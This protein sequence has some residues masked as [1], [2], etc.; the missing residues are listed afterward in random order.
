MGKRSGLFVIQWGR[1]PLWCEN[2]LEG[3]ALFWRLLRSGMCWPLAQDWRVFWQPKSDVLHVFLGNLFTVPKMAESHS[4]QEASG[5]AGRRKERHGLNRL[6][7]AP[8]LV[9]VSFPA[10]PLWFL[11]KWRP[12][13][14][15]KRREE[16]KCLCCEFSPPPHTTS[17]RSP[18]LSIDILWFN[19]SWLFSLW[20]NRPC[21]KSEC[22]AKCVVPKPCHST[23]SLYRWKIFKAA[24]KIKT[25]DRRRVLWKNVNQKFWNHTREK[26][27]CCFRRS[28]KRCAIKLNNV[29]RRLRRIS[30]YI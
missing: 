15:E 13:P 16:V 1:I 11:S 9:V 19:K 6:W 25:Y 2:Y 7:L 18:P 24:C 4:R 28:Y 23:F 8:L 5:E 20:P 3:T 27:M 10:E 14:R 22:G 26:T 29:N 12:F 21:T 17:C 30:R